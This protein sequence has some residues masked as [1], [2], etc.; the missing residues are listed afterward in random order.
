[1]REAWLDIG[2][3]NGDYYAKLASEDHQKMFIV[4]DPN[5][6][7]ANK[8]SNIRFIQSRISS[9]ELAPLASESVSHV[10]TNY[11]LPQLVGGQMDIDDKNKRRRQEV[12]SNV[13]L[14]FLNECHRILKS[15]GEIQLCEAKGFL[16]IIQGLLEKNGFNLVQF[17]PTNIDERSEMINKLIICSQLV[18]LSE[19]K[20]AW[21]LIA[22]K[23]NTA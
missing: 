2:G 17:A 6:Q 22:V 14:G 19:Q 7:R 11:L 18:S 12:L 3:S 4:L 5:V 1:M 23:K 21:T 9:T 16:Q 13:L 15:G 20:I 10:D 8:H